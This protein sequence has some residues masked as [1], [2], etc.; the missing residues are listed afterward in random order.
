[1][2][3]SSSVPEGAA[4][5]VAWECDSQ[6]CMN[7]RTRVVPRMEL[8]LEGRPLCPL[9]LP[10]LLSLRVNSAV[11]IVGHGTKCRV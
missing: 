5:V 2:D 4:A 8:R 6:S 1:M 11:C 7:A 9:P 10:A 3:S